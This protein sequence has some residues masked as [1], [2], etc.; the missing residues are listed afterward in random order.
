MYTEATVCPSPVPAA[1]SPRNWRQEAASIQRGSPG[2]APGVA[3]P[4]AQLGLQQ[5]QRCPHSGELSKVSYSPKSLCW[6]TKMTCSMASPR[7]FGRFW[8]QGCFI[9]AGCSNDRIWF[10]LHT[11]KHGQ[12][13]QHARFVNTSYSVCNTMFGRGVVRIFFSSCH[14]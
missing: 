6:D 13:L 5:P 11:I 2:G 14:Q 4:S 12:P 3:M 9:K 1:T 8:G 10:Y 7:A